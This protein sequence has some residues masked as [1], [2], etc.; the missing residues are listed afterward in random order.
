MVVTSICLLCLLGGSLEA[1]EIEYVGSYDAPDHANGV[2]VIG[3]YAYVADY[4][5]GLQIIDISDPANPSWVSSYD[6]DDF[7]TDIAVYAN[8]AYLITANE[9]Y[10]SLWILDIGNQDPTFASALGLPHFSQGIFVSGNY[11][12]IACSYSGLWIMDVSNPSNPLLIGTYD[13]PDQAMDVTVS[14]SYAYLANEY[15]G[16]RILD[17]SNIASPILVGSYEDMILLDIAVSGDYA[18]NASIDGLYIINIS[19]PSDPSLV[20]R[21]GAPPIGNVAISGHLAYLGMQFTGIYVLNIAE[22]SMPY[23]MDT[24]SM[25]GDVED[26]YVCGVYIYVVD[27]DSLI[28]L[29]FNPTGIED[30]PNPLS[31]SPSLS[32]NYP[33]PFNAQTR[34]DFALPQNTHVKIM[35]FDISGRTVATA[36]DRRFEAGNHSVAWD[37]GDLTSGIYF[38]RISA[39]Q[40][41]DTRKMILIK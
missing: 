7:A 9:Y 21:Y 1:Q 15:S 17:V 3:S 12:F 36:V 26:I 8:Y 22:P 14:G 28:I 25:S 40:F 37:A 2:V 27:W 10:S 30:E 18:F 41:S 6:I 34:I 16:M 20:V 24:Y 19:D 39:G 29:R 35:I 4:A 11:A 32:Q 13:T 5:S 38:Y 23:L 31:T 33:N